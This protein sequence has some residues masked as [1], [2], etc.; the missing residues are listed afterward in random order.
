MFTAQAQN[1]VG[2]ELDSKIHIKKGFPFREATQLFL[3]QMPARHKQ[4]LV[5]Y[6]WDFLQRIL[7]CQE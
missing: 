1:M 6:Y 4:T 5:I 3:S 2:F 7:Q